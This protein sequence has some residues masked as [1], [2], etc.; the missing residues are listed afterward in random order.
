[1]PHS[2][3]KIDIP[4][5]DLLSYVFPQGKV[6]SDKPIWIDADDTSNSLSPK[7]VLSLVKRFGV[8][9]DSIGVHRGEAVMMY[10]RNHIL[11]PAFYLGVVG[12]GRIFTGCNP[13]YGVKETSYQLENTGAKLLLVEPTFLDTVLEAAEQVG[14]ARDRIYL[15]SDKPCETQ[16]GVK[17]WRSMLG[18]NAEAEGWHW[19]EMNAEDS[20]KTVAVLN[21]SSGT[22][23]LPKG[24][25][26]SHQN[27]IANVEQS[28]YMRDLEQPYQ[29]GGAPEERWLGFLPLY[30]AYGE[31]SISG[32]MYQ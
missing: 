8:G 11:I 28:V 9:L 20:K 30:H 27:I 4:A 14:L 31:C 32:I 24:V 22:T 23:G 17:D 29:R 7:Q 15:F 13:A 25:M 12:S 16:Q 1:M 18:S 19:H 26:I 10:T 6:P 5:I 3:Y 21:Y 2:P